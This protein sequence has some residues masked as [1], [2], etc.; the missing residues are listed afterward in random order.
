MKQKVISMTNKTQN[1]LI[2]WNHKKV[3]TDLNYIEQ[4]LIL[5]SA[6]TATVTI[7]VFA[8]LSYIPINITSFPTELKLCLII[9]GI[10]NYE[11]IIEKKKKEHDK[12]LLLQKDILNTTEFLFS[13]HLIDWSIIHDEFA[14]VNNVLRE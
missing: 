4:S 11:P 1:N 7:S 13:K 8:S 2:S 5:A 9:A 3:F 10:K 14:S 6:I 12:I